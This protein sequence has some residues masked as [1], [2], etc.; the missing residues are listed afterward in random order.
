MEQAIDLYLI[1]GFLG[2]GKTTLLRNMIEHF[3]AGRLGVLV[4][5]FG[6]IGID[7]VLV[8]RAGLRLVEINQGSV[9]CACLKDGFVRT[10]KAFSEQDIQ[11]LLIESSG[12]ADP[13]GMVTILEGLAP[14]LSRPYQYR[15]NICMVDCTTFL[16][17][18][19]SLIAVQNQAA[20][21]DLLLVNKTDLVDAQTLVEIHQI[22][23]SLNAQA[24]IQNTTYAD[25]SDTLLA[26]CLYCHGFEGTC[27]NTPA[28]RPYSYTLYTDGVCGVCAAEQFCGAL[29]GH[30]I[31][32]KG[33]LNTGERW[34]HVDAVAEQVR[35]ETME[36]HGQAPSTQGR[37][38]FIAVN[39][40]DARQAIRTAWE[41]FCHTPIRLEKH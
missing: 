26:E 4:N 19:D 21:A 2:A 35:L 8:E 27:S 23:R 14:Y 1:S 18:V 29:V 28:R 10:L 16:D 34:L 12:M 20:A 11:A 24:P 40:K 5:E 15:G 22:L 3:D 6:S 32:I 33:F 25:V 13:A 39:K 30:V 17:Y 7:G 31:R 9:F 38:V 37:L 36:F 41:Q